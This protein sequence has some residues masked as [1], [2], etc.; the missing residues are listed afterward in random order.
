MFR[1]RCRSPSLRQRFHIPGGPTPADTGTLWLAGLASSL[2]YQS[3]RFTSVLMVI[4][5]A[6][7]SYDSS[8][9]YRP[10]DTSDPS[11]EEVRPPLAD[12]LFEQREAFDRALEVYDEC[13]PVV[14]RLR[15]HAS[16]TLETEMERLRIQA[17][18]EEQ[19][20]VELHAIRYY[21]RRTLLHCGA[22]WLQR[23]AGVTNYGQLLDEVR[24]WRTTHPSEEVRFVTFNYDTLLEHACRSALQLEI[25]SMSGYTSRVYRI[26]KPHGSVNWVRTIEPGIAVDPE[27]VE[28]SIIALGTRVR[29]GSGFHLS[30]EQ[31]QTQLDGRYVYPALAL[32][33]NTKVDFECPRDH[34][35]ELKDDVTVVTKLLVI[36]W[37]ATEP[38]FLEFWGQPR[39]SSVRDEISKIGI[40]AGSL[41]E[42]TT[43]Q[44]NLTAAGIHGK[45]GLSR[46]GFSEFVTGPELASFLAD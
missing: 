12:D 4:F 37:R 46:G 6:G 34:L 23:T 8:D 16:T 22:S 3:R 24:H 25:R 15:R 14:P 9:T 17:E 21:L 10:G 26:Y 13:L 20:A 5:G 40:V 30:A 42:A 19:R 45:F 33:V 11:I 29:L 28:H 1:V 38:H 35:A 31:E 7:A 43:V 18:H 41:N 2:N 32:P 27:N 36:G 39:P 44:N